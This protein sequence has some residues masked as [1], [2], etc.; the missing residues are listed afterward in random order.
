MS[1]QA[2]VIISTVASF[3]G[4]FLLLA[5]RA[6]T[7]PN[8]SPAAVLIPSGAVA[9]H[10]D[11]A[12]NAA[13]TPASFP[14]K[15]AWMLFTQINQKS[16]HQ[17]P[18]GRQAGNP[19]T[20]DA[21]WETWADDPLTFPARPDPANP[22]QWPVPAQPRPIKTLFRRALIAKAEIPK[23]AAAA[24]S[25][26]IP[27]VQPGGIAAGGVGEEVH[28]NQVA[29][30]YIIKNGL[31]YR[32]GISAF[33]A[34]AASV[35]NDN[36]AFTAAG[37]VF[38]RGAIEV[39]ANW[40]AI[41]E[42]DKPKYHWNYSYIAP[43]GNAPA[44][45]QL[46]GLVAIHIISKDLPNWMWCTFEHVDNPG[47]GDYIG[48]HDSFGANP[49]H[50]PSNTD[51]PGKVYPAEQLTADVLALFQTS[52]MNA[53]PDWGKRFQN[54]RLKGSQTDFTDSSGRPLLLSNSVT[55]DGFVPTASCITC[56]ARACVNSSGSSSFPGF[57]EEMALPL[58]ESSIGPQTYNGLPNPGWYFQ[59]TGVTTQL[60]NLQT[61]FV[62]AIPMRARS[63]K[64]TSKP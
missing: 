63:I 32:E 11:T 5:T 61:D 50:V 62:W 55:E 1:Q 10:D 34:N 37:V 9:P 54:Y 45:T 58:I 29:F 26:R 14:D 18:V 43:T 33:F 20:N 59:N 30:D 27:Q 47:R 39:K 22:P 44:S 53:D 8:D 49:S 3:A 46:L 24:A 4:V 13:A 41:E 28:R 52:G 36:A 64:N 51:K 56:H 42:K 57:G 60:L 19:Q 21:I 7:A 16:P 15:F 2:R 48:I 12:G 31:W 38:P 40:V 6:S 35:A 17:H 23:T 25:L